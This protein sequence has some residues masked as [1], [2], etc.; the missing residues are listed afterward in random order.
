MDTKSNQLFLLIVLTCSL[1]FAGC[2]GLLPNKLV[3]DS[4]TMPGN[5]PVLKSP[6]DW[7]L[8]FDDVSFVTSDSVML[9]GWLLKGASDK[10]IVFSHFGIQSSRSGYTPK[11]KG[12]FKPYKKEIEYLNTMKHLV[13]NGYSVLMYD[14]RNHGLSDSGICPYITGGLEESKDV[15]AAVKFLTD[16]P[17]Y[18]DCK[19][20]LLAYCNGSNATTYAFGAENGLHDYNNIKAYIAVQPMF[21]NATFLEC[22]GIPNKKVEKANE[23]NI[24]RG[25]MDLY[26][27]S[28]PFITSINVPTMVAQGI[29]DPWTDMEKV[30]DFY[31]QLLVEKEMFWM[32]GIDERLAG[33]HYFDHSPEKMLEFFGKYM[34]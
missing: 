29:E 26:N 32:E 22:Y 31:R 19:I 12:A 21:S 6:S 10:V 23:L 15:I 17:E 9:R 1:F 27:S 24:T 2:A 30:N 7:G 18:K 34:K 11:G 8:D 14:M 13:N 25:G 16:Q 3:A 28:W 5:S 4:V 33:Y 20:G